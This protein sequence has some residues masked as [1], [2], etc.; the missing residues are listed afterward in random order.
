MTPKRYESRTWK[1]DQYSA[2]YASSIWHVDH[3]SMMLILLITISIVEIKESIRHSFT[4]CRI[5]GT[6]CSRPQILDINLVDSLY[7][8][9][10]DYYLQTWQQVNIIYHL[11]NS[12][13]VL[14]PT[15]ALRSWYLR[16]YGC[17]IQCSLIQGH[18][19]WT[20]MW[21]YH[22]HR[23]WRWQCQKVRE[24]QSIRGTCPCPP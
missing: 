18:S 22:H 6:S 7:K 16:G 5:S 13:H 11:P 1:L 20:E 23:K 12:N 3:Y 24:G 14:L 9:R 19:P 10:F 15:H 4:I 21:K 2:S 17:R 8:F